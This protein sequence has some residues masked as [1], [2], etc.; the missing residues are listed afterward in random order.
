MVARDV[1]IRKPGFTSAYAN[2]TAFEADVAGFNA[3]YLMAGQYD[4]CYESIFDLVVEPS[5]LVFGYYLHIDCSYA[6][7]IAPG[8]R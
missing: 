4:S 2:K 7:I 8:L 3:L 5:T 6:S 1:R